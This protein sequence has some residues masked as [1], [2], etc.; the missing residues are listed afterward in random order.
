MP[1][2]GFYRAAYGGVQL[3][4]SRLRT[5]R[6]R[7][8]VVHEMS[9]GSDHVVQDRGPENVTASAELLFDYMKGDL[10][11]PLDR[12]RELKALCDGKA[13]MLT[14]PTEGS[15]RALIGPFEEEIDEHGVIHANVDFTAAE[16]VESVIPAGAASIPASGEGLVDA[17]ADAL[18]SELA[19]LELTDPGIA[20]AAK[21]STSAWAASEDLNPR[22]VLVETG[23]YTE[24][25][26]AQADTM[27]DDIGKWEAFK[28][29]L[30]LADSVRS[31][32]EAVTSDTS[33]TV[34]FRIGAATT[35]RT[36]LAAEYGAEAADYYYQQVMR[37]NDIATPGLLEEGQTLQ[38]PSPSARAR[39]G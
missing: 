1:N 3:W 22:T 30:L 38:L 7:T 39:N 25:L 20:S 2:P 12:V 32:A 11:T 5:K 19:E 8:L 26:G 37:L 34:L 28:R 15:F 31:A 23:T 29:T 6:G 24:Q 13:R 21:S 4:V 14:H 17:S 36:L 27:Q 35:L 18:S 16:A 9:A 33:S 10:L